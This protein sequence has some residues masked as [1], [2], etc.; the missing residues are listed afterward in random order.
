MLARGVGLLPGREHFIF[1]FYLSDFRNKNKVPNRVIILEVAS[2]LVCEANTVSFPFRDPSN[3]RRPIAKQS[4]D[5]SSSSLGM[6]MLYPVVRLQEDKAW[7]WG[8]F[9]TSP[10]GDSDIIPPQTQQ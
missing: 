4:P 3:G 2:I 1:F 7:E 8:R 9:W 10:H 6:G 5:D